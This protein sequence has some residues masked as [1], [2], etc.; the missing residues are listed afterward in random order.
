M[1]NYQPLKHPRKI[2]EIADGEIGLW[3]T[4]DGGTTWYPIEVTTDGTL[5]NRNKYA[6]RNLDDAADPIYVGY[7]SDDDSWQIMKFTSATG[8]ALYATGSSGYAAAWA[9]RIGQ[10]YS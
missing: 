7:L 1:A 9:A 10:S 8:I 5:L 4:S 6:F 3:G 2:S